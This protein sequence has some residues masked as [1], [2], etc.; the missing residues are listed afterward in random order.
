[1]P[2]YDQLRV[3]AEAGGLVFF[4]DPLTRTRVDAEVT[5]SVQETPAAT[6][7]VFNPPDGF[8][9]SVR[10][11]SLVRVSAGWNGA[12]GVIFAG[13][14]VPDGVEVDADNRDVQVK[15]KI[16]PGN[17]AWRKAVSV[18]RRGQASYRD[19]VAGIVADMGLTLG[20]L[21][22]SLAPTYLP[23]G[24]AWEGPGWRALRTLA[25]SA[26]CEIAFDGTTVNFVRTAQGLSSNLES[27]PK[28]TQSSTGG[29]IIGSPKYTDK[30]LAFEVIFDPRVSLGRRIALEFYDKFNGRQVRGVYVP[31][32]VQHNFSSH[33]TARTTRVTARFAGGL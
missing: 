19:T 1:V 32:A 5:Y 24:F 33:G 2:T 29:N 20:E 26:S 22:L 3:Q 15:I 25:A 27:V 23:R 14:P 9:A 13:T 30:G 8:A 31:T 12:L 11:G 18:V 10:R 16:R 21:D 6:V 4:G 17:D 7:T 28:F